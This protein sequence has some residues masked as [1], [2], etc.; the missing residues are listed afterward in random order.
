[1]QLGPARQQGTT[2][3]STIRGVVTGSSGPEAGV[4]VIAETEELETP[5]RKIVVT[6]EMGRYLLPDLPDAS[7]TLWARGY[8]LADS[9]PVVARSGGTV[10]LRTRDAETPQQAAE[11]YPANHW[12]SLLRLHGRTSFRAQATTAMALGRVYK[13]LGSGSI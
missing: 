5:F 12:Y 10:D 4:W 2:E 6:D 9:A 7:Y 13:P 3:D 8:G 11:I 1:M